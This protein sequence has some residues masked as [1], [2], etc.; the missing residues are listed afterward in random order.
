MNGARTQCPGESTVTLHW[1]GTVVCG[2]TGNVQEHE[3]VLPQAQRDEAVGELALLRP[4]R[5]C[6]SVVALRGN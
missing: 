1:Q 3:C 6:I 4:G 5:G 2:S